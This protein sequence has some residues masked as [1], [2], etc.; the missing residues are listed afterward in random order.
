M[1]KTLSSIAI[2]YVNTAPQRRINNFI[3]NST[4]PSS[5][6]LTNKA[7]S[8]SNTSTATTETKKP[9]KHIA[10]KIKLTLTPSERIYLSLS[11]MAIL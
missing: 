6:T 3:P 4:V 11:K 2:P 10:E 5:I 7:K 9:E 1:R 8:F